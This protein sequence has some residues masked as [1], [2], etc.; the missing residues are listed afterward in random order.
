MVLL[1][2]GDEALSRHFL[3]VVELD[4]SLGLEAEW[5]NVN[6]NVVE[7]GRLVG[8][9]GQKSGPVAEF[10]LKETVGAETIVAGNRESENL[11][12]VGLLKDLFGSLGLSEHRHFA[13]ATLESV[14]SALE[15]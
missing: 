6:W 12:K 11:L 3:P 9:G 10:F 14:I 8:T 1:Q 4:H 15:V 7:V 5:A 13:N 2:F